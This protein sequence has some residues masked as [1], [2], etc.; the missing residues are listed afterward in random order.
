MSAATKRTV[1]LTVDRS[2]LFAGIGA[3]EAHVVRSYQERD[4]GDPDL[5]SIHVPALRAAELLRPDDPPID[6]VSVDVEGTE[7]DVLRGLDLARNSRACW[8]WRH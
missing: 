6:F 3:D 5:Y 1:E 4:G 8:W 2:G 7:I